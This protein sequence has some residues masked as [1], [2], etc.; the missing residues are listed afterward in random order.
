MD[1]VIAP[2]TVSVM[3]SKNPPSM[4]SVM[5]SKSPPVAVS[6]TTSKSSSPMVSVMTSES[7]SSMVYITATKSTASTVS[8]MTSKSSLYMSSPDDTEDRD[9]LAYSDGKAA[10]HHILSEVLGQPW[11]LLAEALERSGFDEIQ[12]VLLMNPAKR[13]MLTF[14]N[15]NG[16]V[17][18]LPQAEKNKLLNIKLFSLYCERNGKPIVDWMKVPRLILIGLCSTWKKSR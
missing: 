3:A 10:L 6:I 5:T 11:W 12:D 18:P 7:S 1:N 13:D 4:V 9:V 8:V 15:A 14:L 17:T 2:V 16:M